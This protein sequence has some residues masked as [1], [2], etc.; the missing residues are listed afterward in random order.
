MSFIHHRFRFAA[1]RNQPLDAS[2]HAQL[3]P[4]KDQV[5][6]TCKKAPFA[7]VTENEGVDRLRIGWKVAHEELAHITLEAVAQNDG[8]SVLD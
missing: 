1:R 5:A 7:R 3:M 2:T 8:H 6:V 4:I